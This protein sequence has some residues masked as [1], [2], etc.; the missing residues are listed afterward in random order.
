M[1]NTMIAI[2]ALNIL[3][4]GTNLASPVLADLVV[5]RFDL[6]PRTGVTSFPVPS[7]RPNA[8][9]KV[10]GVDAFPSAGAVAH[11]DNGYAWFDA[12]DADLMHANGN[13]PVTCARMGVQTDRVEFGSRN[14]DGGAQKDI[15]I[16]RDRQV[17][18]KFDATGMT[19]YG[20]VKARQF[21]NIP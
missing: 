12:C 11:P 17:V 4:L 10:I 7:F 16:V 6:A 13:V 9:G 19:V 8:S 18:A 3:I 21:E 15:W 1:K 5:S 2:T 14:F 20:T